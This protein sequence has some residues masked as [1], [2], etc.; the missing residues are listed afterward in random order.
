M[1][2]K[3][4]YGN[5]LLGI[6]AVVA[7]I[8]I[9][10]LGKMQKLEFIKNN[11]PGPGMFP[12]LCAVAIVVCGLALILEF[13]L[14]SGKKAGEKDPELEENVLNPH[15]LRNLL[16][17][18]IMGGLVLVLTEYLGLL[19]CLCL[20]IVAYIKIQGKDPW[21][22]AIAIAIG[23]TVFLYFVFVMFLRVPVP[24]GPMGF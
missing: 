3:M 24:K 2:L 22:R 16:I 6:V 23:T 5:L 1:K 18:M 10:V 8:M 7:G 11:M 20:S 21:W 13:F 9:Y 12:T 14:K 17:L 19:T 15:E 4:K